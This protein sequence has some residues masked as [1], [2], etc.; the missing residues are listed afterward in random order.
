MLVLF[1]LFASCAAPA[2]VRQEQL[3]DGL[4]IG[5][6]APEPAK[7]NATQELIVTLHDAQGQPIDAATVYLDLTMPAMP[8]GTNR[9]EAEPLGQGRYRVRTALTMLGT[10]ELT[11]VAERAGTEYRAIFTREVVE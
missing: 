1:M 11:V 5:L 6:E 3:V 10:W 8:M 9:P 2:T 4:T 7:L